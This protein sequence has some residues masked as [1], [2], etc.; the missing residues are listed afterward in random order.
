MYW[1]DRRVLVTGGASFIGSHLVERLVELGADVTA[2]DNFSSGK[3]ENLSQS[4]SWIHI[5][6]MDLEWCSLEDIIEAFKGQEVVFHLAAAN[7]GRGYIHNHPADVYSNFA[8]DYH[9]FEACLK[10]DVER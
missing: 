5:V 8:I 4:L 1:K 9:V 7:G 3:M 2:V 10:A 6:R